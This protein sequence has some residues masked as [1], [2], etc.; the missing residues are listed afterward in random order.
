MSR[1]PMLSGTALRSDEIPDGT[2]S[3]EWKVLTHIPRKG[4]PQQ[5]NLTDCV[6]TSVEHSTLIVHFMPVLGGGGW[7]CSK[8]RREFVVKR[9]ACHNPTQASGWAE[10]LWRVMHGIAPDGAPPPRKRWL[11][12]INP[13]S[14]PGKAVKLFG[15]LRPVLEANR[16][17]LTELVTAGAG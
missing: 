14:G 11:V 12:L 6:G 8:L 1:T 13:V 5:I 15:Q 17:A 10:A 7:G 9:F 4:L 2:L 16:V 3:L